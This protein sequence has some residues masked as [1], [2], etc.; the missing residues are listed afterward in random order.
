MR[1]RDRKRPPVDPATRQSEL[2]EMMR[3]TMPEKEQLLVGFDEIAAFWTKAGMPVSRRT[4]E[5]WPRAYGMPVRPGRRG[6]WRRERPVASSFC[7]AAWLIYDP[8]AA[9]VRGGSDRIGRMRG[10]R[11]PRGSVATSP[12]PTPAESSSRPLEAA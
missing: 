7:L 4:V 10:C 1:E 8:R 2:V 12:A 3:R 11:T 9:H 6:G 5:T